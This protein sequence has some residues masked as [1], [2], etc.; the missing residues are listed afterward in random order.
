M[1][2]IVAGCPI[3]FPDDWRSISQNVAS[4]NILARDLINFIYYISSV[5]GDI[6]E[7]AVNILFSFRFQL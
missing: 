4:L 7:I 1:C 2:D 5:N 6:S 3:T